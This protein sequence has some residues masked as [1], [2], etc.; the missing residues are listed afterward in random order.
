MCSSLAWKRLQ[1]MKKAVLVFAG[2]ALGEWNLLCGSPRAQ[3][4]LWVHPQA[5]LFQGGK[6][7]MDST[8]SS[9]LVSPGLMISLWSVLK[10]SGYILQ[11]QS[12][13]AYCLCVREGDSKASLLSRIQPK[14]ELF[15]S[16]LWGYS[17]VPFTSVTMWLQ[18][19]N[20]QDS[21][22]L[23]NVSCCCYY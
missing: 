10:H 16:V 6:E 14:I 12:V 18:K 2:A 21:Q 9:F 13:S 11:V 15:P 7:Q 8:C 3:L 20:A 1:T 5:L 17:P 22:C 23:G 19:D 4:L